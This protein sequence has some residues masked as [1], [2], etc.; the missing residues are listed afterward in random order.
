MNP[1]QEK[2]SE[3]PLAERRKQKNFKMAGGA[4]DF[5]SQLDHRS[6]G[7]RGEAT[8]HFIVF[9]FICLVSLL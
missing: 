6:G 2:C 1:R 3:F 7:G 4:E 9:L 5:I 8:A